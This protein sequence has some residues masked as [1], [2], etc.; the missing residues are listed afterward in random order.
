MEIKE[1]R[2]RA[3]GSTHI[4]G[5]LKEQGFEFIISIPVS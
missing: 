3:I 4:N 1:E 2:I 5:T